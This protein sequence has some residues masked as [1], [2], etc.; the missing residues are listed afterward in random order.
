MFNLLIG[1]VN[2]IVS[3][4][5]VV[6]LVILKEGL[7]FAEE[8]VFKDRIDISKRSLHSISLL[9]TNI[10]NCNPMYA[11]HFRNIPKTK[12]IRYMSTQNIQKC[13]INP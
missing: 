4:V 10:F 13:N 6:L 7:P 11:T 12:G 2:F 1:G 8:T 5:I 9:T 3:G